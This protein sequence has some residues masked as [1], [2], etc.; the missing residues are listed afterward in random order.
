MRVFTK[1]TNFR[2]QR[3][4]DIAKHA[5]QCMCCGAWNKGD[6]VAAHSNALK[7]GKG[8][9]VKAHDLVAYVCRECHDA[10]DGRDMGLS[11]EARHLMFLEAFYTTQLWLLR[12]G[13]L[14]VVS[15]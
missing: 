3:L 8:K 13:F 6:V 14:K 15:K 4:L 1:E 12:E 9:G 11:R 5:P 2:C 7:H 10:I